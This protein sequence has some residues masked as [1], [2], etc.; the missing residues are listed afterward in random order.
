MQRLHAQGQAPKL[1]QS[2]VRAN[3]PAS[4]RRRNGSTAVV[5]ATPEEI[6]GGVEVAVV[7]AG[8]GRVRTAAEEGRE[9][10]DGV[11]HHHTTPKK[12]RSGACPGS[13]DC[14]VQ[15]DLL[16]AVIVRCSQ[17]G[18]GGSGQ[19]FQLMGTITIP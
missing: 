15:V 11:G 18:S 19:L 6:I 13:Q 10:R 3:L 7:G 9:G 5:V 14:E 1:S 4:S 2:N 16:R 8:G 17:D 12:Q